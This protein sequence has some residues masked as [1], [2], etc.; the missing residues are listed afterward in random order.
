MK[1]RKLG[2]LAG[3][4]RFCQSSQ[5]H[6]RI[7]TSYSHTHTSSCHRW[8]STQVHIANQEE[9]VLKVNFTWLYVS[10]KIHQQCNAWPEVLNLNVSSSEATADI[11]LH[12]CRSFYTSSGHW[13]NTPLPLTLN[14][15]SC[16][17]T[18]HLS[19]FFWLSCWDVA[20]RFLRWIGVIYF[21]STWLIYNKLLKWQW[22]CSPL[23]PK[24][25]LSW[26]EMICRQ[27][28]AWPQQHHCRRRDRK[29]T[30]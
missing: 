7:T 13:F 17:I 27:G 22:Q 8:D 6:S 10:A 18:M 19:M 2:K 9:L 11:I 1:N 4:S 30:F 24:T 23:T 26:C 20:E 14:I 12:A 5:V 15:Y 21:T 16:L 3:G 25:V 29:E 28:E